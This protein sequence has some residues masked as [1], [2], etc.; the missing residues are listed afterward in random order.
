MEVVTFIAIVWD[1][2]FCDG[3]VGRGYRTGW[4]DHITYSMSKMK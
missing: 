2:T 3:E 1:K 4:K